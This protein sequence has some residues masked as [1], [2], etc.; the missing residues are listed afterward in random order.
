MR[1]PRSP[2]HLPRR[3]SD[4]QVGLK[5]VLLLRVLSK[6]A[7]GSPSAS[8]SMSLSRPSSTSRSVAARSL[9]RRG[10]GKPARLAVPDHV[11]DAARRRGDHRA[12]AGQGLADHI[13][14][15][16]PARR[17]HDRMVLG[18]HPRHLLVGDPIDELD[19][20]DR[21]RRGD[22][23]CARMDVPSGPLIVSPPTIVRA[24]SASGSERT[25]EISSVIPLRRSNR[26]R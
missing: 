15:R 26:F 4:L 5:R 25:A 13:G 24:R 17:H 12:V 9:G 6:A 22:S 18:D 11:H 2:S 3:S 23:A 20:L 7:R 10:V 21:R 19:P 14:E 16:L 1:R 8:I